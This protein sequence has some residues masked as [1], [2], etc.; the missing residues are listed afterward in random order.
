MNLHSTQA[1]VDPAFPACGVLIGRWGGVVHAVSA[2]RGPVHDSG[3][4]PMGDDTVYAQ[5][6]VMPRREIV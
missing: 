4:M 5:R 6:D 3:R 1:A 2:F